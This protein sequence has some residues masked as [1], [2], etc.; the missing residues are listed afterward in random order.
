MQNLL[1]V[2][3]VDDSQKTIIKKQKLNVEESFQCTV[4]GFSFTRKG[5]LKRHQ[6]NNHGKYNPSTDQP[7]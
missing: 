2:D 3:F 7:Y 6:I 5:N 1:E 4:C